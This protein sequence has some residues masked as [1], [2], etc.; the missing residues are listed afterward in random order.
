MSKGAFI[1]RGTILSAS[2]DGYKVKSFDRDGIITPPIKPISTDTTYTV[3][4]TVYFF[5]F[6][7]GTGKI[8]CAA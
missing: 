7:D 5:L 6:L 4:D 1:E 2:T 8:L 3:G